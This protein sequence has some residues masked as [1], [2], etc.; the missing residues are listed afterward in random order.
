MVKHISQQI[1]YIYL[2][3]GLADLNFLTLSTVLK[4]LSGKKSSK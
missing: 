3:I 4:I 2:I 1:M